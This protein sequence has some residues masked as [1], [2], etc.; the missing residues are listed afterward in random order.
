MRAM[1]VLT[2]G[3]SVLLNGCGGGVS[4]GF[5]HY[6]DDDFFAPAIS[7]AASPT[8]VR[9]GQTV[10]LVAA[11]SDQESGVDRVS[12]FRIDDT[13]SVVQLGSDGREPFE[14]VV[15][16]PSDGRTTL[17]VFAQARDFAGNRTD[18]A[19]LTIAVTP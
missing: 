13:D 2:L 19:T 12:F 7:L 1:V 17:R 14:W 18:S 9:A 4:F 11:A 5:G 10:Q 3:A 8:T 15:T 6:D 16:A